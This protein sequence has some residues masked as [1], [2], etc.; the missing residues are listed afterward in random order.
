LAAND[1]FLELRN[2]L[3]VPPVSELRKNLYSL[4]RQDD[5]SFLKLY[6]KFITALEKMDNTALVASRGRKLK[7]GELLLCYRNASNALGDFMALVE[8]SEASTNNEV[9]ISQ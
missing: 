5:E 2:S 3:R 4:V 6:Q 1:A 9:T 8:G 7:E